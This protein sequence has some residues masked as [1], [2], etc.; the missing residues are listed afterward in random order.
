MSKT[1][2]FDSTL[3]CQSGKRIPYYDIGYTDDDTKDQDLRWFHE[4]YGYFRLY[5]LLKVD[6]ENFIAEDLY[7]VMRTDNEKWNL[8]VEHPELLLAEG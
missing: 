2:Y 8:Y 1:V 7:H 5:R 4:G 6:E 3:K